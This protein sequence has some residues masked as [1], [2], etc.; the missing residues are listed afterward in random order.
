[1]VSTRSG[2]IVTVG[3]QSAE[4][5]S[6]RGGATKSVPR[7]RAEGEPVHACHCSVPWTFSS[8]M[9]TLLGAMVDAAVRACVLKVHLAADFVPR[10]WLAADVRLC[11]QLGELSR[12]AVCARSV[13]TLRK[14]RC[15]SAVI[16]VRRMQ[17]SP[18]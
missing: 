12:A 11:L 6:R 5:S 3:A 15:Y 13:Q 9:C 17:H 4:V 18:A 7:T 1:M 16:S 8:L 14:K 10:T 2:S